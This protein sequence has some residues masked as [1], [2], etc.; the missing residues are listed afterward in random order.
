LLRVILD[1]HSNIACG[2][3]LKATPKIAQLW[4]ELQVECRESFEAHGISCEVLNTVF[5]Q[6]LSSFLEPYRRAQGKARVAEKTPNNVFYFQHLHYLFPDSPLIHVV[7][8]GRDVVCSLLEMEWADPATGK[9]LEYTTDPA[10]AARYWLDAVE[11]GRAAA[12][13]PSAS[14]QYYEIRYE[15]LVTR[16]EPTLQS[17]FEFIGEPYEPSVLGFHNQ[18]RELGHESSASQVVR[19]LSANSVCRWRSDLVGRNREIVKEVIG[20]MVERLGYD[21][22]SYW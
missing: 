3:E 12:E 4:Y 11:V 17:L 21:E 20:A 9:Q 8:D 5:G 13:H 10:A 2:P 6:L 7:R 19:P 22:P 14:R 15:D 16:P 1:S 18:S